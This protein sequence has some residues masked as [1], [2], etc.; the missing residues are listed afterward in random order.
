MFTLFLSFLGTI[1][2]WF[3]TRAALQLKFLALRCQIN[4]L[5]RS[6]RRRVR[7]MEVDRLIGTLLRECLDQFTLLNKSN[8]VARPS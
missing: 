7:L 6:Q 5:R 4:M 3:Q 8:F 2:S 1:R